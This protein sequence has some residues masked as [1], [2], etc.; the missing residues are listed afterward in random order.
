MRRD[1]KERGRLGDSADEV[2][3]LNLIPKKQGVNWIKQTQDMDY[4]THGQY[5]NKTSG[6]RKN[7]LGNI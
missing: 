7:E 1:L 5:G 6:P 4:C 3:L 2:K